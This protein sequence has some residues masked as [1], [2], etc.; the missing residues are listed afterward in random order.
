MANIG[1]EELIKQVDAKLGLKMTELTIEQEP[2][3]VLVN[4]EK[5][6]AT[7]REKEGEDSDAYKR[8]LRHEERYR[9]LLANIP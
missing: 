5:I 1:S 3:T 8:C 6:K 2:A 4:L 7:V 9:S